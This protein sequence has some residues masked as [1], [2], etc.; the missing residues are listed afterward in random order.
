MVTLAILL[1][2]RIA[3]VLLRGVNSLQYMLLA[4]VQL[5]HETVQNER[6]MLNIK[7]LQG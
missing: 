2:I 7:W 5:S 4:F 1:S 6:D 3:Y